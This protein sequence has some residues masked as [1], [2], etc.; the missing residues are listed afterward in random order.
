VL[1][2]VTE[3][4]RQFGSPGDGE[5]ILLEAVTRQQLVKKQKTEKIQYVLQ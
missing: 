1:K 2:L 5:C 4:R 3:E